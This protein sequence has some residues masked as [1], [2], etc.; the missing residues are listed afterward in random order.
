MQVVA[1]PLKLQ[2]IKVSQHLQ[3]IK[4]CSPASH[5]RSGRLG[6]QAS[7]I[8]IAAVL[9]ADVSRGLHKQNYNC[10]DYRGH[11]WDSLGNTSGPAIRCVSPYWGYIGRAAGSGDF[12]PSAVPQGREGKGRAE[13]SKQT[14]G[15]G[16]PWGDLQYHR[17]LFLGKTLVLLKL[18]P[19][20]P[21]ASRGARFSLRALFSSQS[22]LRSGE[23]SGFWP[24]QGDEVIRCQP[25]YC[26]CAKLQ[27]YW[28]CC[29]DLGW[30]EQW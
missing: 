22:L 1:F 23:E 12:C 29:R 3:E 8:N 7:N 9:G 27:R 18:L 17:H 13:L 15:K 2:I 4:A 6:Y 19:V 14:R 5:C 28:S 11:L 24:L 21:L 10:G 20:F 25:A 26:C 16:S 30:Q